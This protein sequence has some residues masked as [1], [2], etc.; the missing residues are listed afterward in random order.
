MEIGNKSIDKLEFISW[1]DV[2]IGVSRVVR[3][4]GQGCSL[5]SRDICDPESRSIIISLKNISTLRVV[6]HLDSRYISCRFACTSIFW[7]DGLQLASC[8]GFERAHRGCPDGYHSPL[9]VFQE[10]KSFAWNSHKFRVNLV[11]RH[12]IF[13]D[14]LKCSW[15]DMERDARYI[16]SHILDFFEEFWREVSSCGR[17]GRRAEIF[18]IDGLI[19][20]RICEMFGDIWREWDFSVFL[21]DR[22]PFVVRHGDFYQSASIGLPYY[23]EG[24][25]VFEDYGSSGLE[26]FSRETHDLPHIRRSISEEE[27]FDIFFCTILKHGVSCDT[28]RYNTSIVDNEDIIR[29]EK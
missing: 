21:K 18:G 10:F 23:L 26:A 1:C 19:E 17:C 8:I 2:E 4:S 12:I 6:I 22:E 7:N 13:V 14:G 20:F 28:S 5:R 27:A 16:H 3:H 9:S 15:T 24:H 25:T 29:M 11:L